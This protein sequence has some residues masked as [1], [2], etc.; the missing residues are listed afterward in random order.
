[1][2]VV[3]C[4]AIDH[5]DITRPRMFDADA[6]WRHTL[7]SVL[8]AKVPSPTK[9][10]NTNAVIRVGAHAAHTS[11]RPQPDGNP[12]QRVESRVWTTGGV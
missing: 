2:G 3:P 6:D 7:D 8:K 11:E 5:N 1:M 4:Q 10:S 12:H 9:S